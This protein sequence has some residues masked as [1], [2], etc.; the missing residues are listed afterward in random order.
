MRAF[1]SQL[2]EA[3]RATPDSAFVARRLFFTNSIDG[4]VSAIGVNVGAFD[5]GVRP[6]S[7]ALAILGGSI[8]FGVAAGFLGALLSERAER[9]REVRDLER[10]LGG[11]L[12]GSVYW[13][14]ALVVPVYVAFWSSLG[15]L[16]FPLL[17]A[18]PYFLSHWGLLGI[19]EA[20]VL[21]N[22]LAVL[23]L[24]FVGALLSRVS[25]ESP[26]LSSLRAVLLGLGA[27]LLVYSIKRVLIGL[28]V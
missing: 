13:R 3:L 25:G 7:M 14:A 8:A 12:R 5:V 26:L 28:A 22:V 4:I 16:L 20:Y 21:S 27:L 11:S 9:I 10:A 6:L 23:A 24:S 2:R 1:F 19:L 15:I 18:S 17:V